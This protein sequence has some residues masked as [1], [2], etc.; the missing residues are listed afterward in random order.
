MVKRPDVVIDVSHLSTV[1]YPVEA[2]R[3]VALVA[4]CATFI[5]PLI[6]IFLRPPI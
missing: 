4:L 5:A 6:K 3:P 2:P 1:K